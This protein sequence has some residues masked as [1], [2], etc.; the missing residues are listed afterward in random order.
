M[1]AEI[2]I[3]KSHLLSDSEF[4]HKTTLQAFY[5][6]QSALASMN[7]G[8]VLIFNESPDVGFKLA[9]HVIH[10]VARTCSQQCFDFGADS[11]NKQI[12]SFIH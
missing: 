10:V 6:I 12:N 11:S 7:H 2:E 1:G 3:E 9:Q 4:A 5:F 8:S